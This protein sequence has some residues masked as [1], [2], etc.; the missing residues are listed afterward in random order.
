MWSALFLFVQVENEMR[1]ANF[2]PL[3]LEMLQVAAENGK[4]QKFC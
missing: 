1:R 2:I 4:L 3:I